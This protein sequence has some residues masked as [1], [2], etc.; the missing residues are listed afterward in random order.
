MRAMTVEELRTLI[1]SHTPPCISVYLPTHRGG[2]PE[3]RHHFDAALHAARGQL[4]ELA[5][6]DAD[7][8]LAPLQELSTP[9]FWKN[10]SLGLAL[11]RSRDHFASYRLPTQVP[12]LSL[13]AP[14]FH[15]RPLLR[16]LQSNQ[17]Y[18]LLS[19]SQNRVAFFKGSADGLAPVDVENLPRSLEGALGPEDRERSVHVHQGARGSKN[20]I[21]GGGGKSDSSRD[22]DLARF[23]RAVD[24][25]LWSVLA[26]E[27][28]P[29]IL[30][31]TERELPLFRSVSRYSHIAQEALHG[32]FADARMED[33]HTKA[34]P[35]VQHIVEARTDEVRKRYDALVSR[36]R[37][38]DEIRGIAS[39]AVQG[40][41][42]QLLLERDARA[43][44]KLDPANGALELHGA[45]RV[46]GEK[47]DDVLD[48]LAEAVLVRGGEVFAVEKA[49][50]P[51]KSPV[52]AILRW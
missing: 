50:M 30:A 42:Y 3:D 36:A 35:I 12:E 25:A 51:S 15:I 7:A 31:S 10:T 6:R 48:D 4:K 23:F 39:Y 1:A 14:S 17:R 46:K 29:L 8:L 19:L 41:V 44:G 5:A 27:T 43:W 22:E 20:A 37:A 49:R 26:H 2:S 16:F 33:M 24:Q 38:L 52:A 18:Y 45:T 32:N 28:V 34:W 9:E 47:G 21:Y 11:F 40:R 13:V